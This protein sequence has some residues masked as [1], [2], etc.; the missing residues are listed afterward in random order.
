MFF[1][2][3]LVCC[4]HIFDI[5]ARCVACRGIL[6]ILLKFITEGK[7]DAQRVFLVEAVVVG[8]DERGHGRLQ[9]PEVHEALPRRHASDPHHGILVV[10]FF[11]FRA[12]ALPVPAARS[13]PT[14]ARSERGQLPLG[15]EH[16]DRLV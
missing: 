15:K 7:G 3:I 6:C 4:C 9:G 1:L 13:C 11:L 12:T 10:V 2:L 16:R 5:G 8:E 14:F